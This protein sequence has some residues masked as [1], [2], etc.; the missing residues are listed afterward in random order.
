MNKKYKTELSGMEVK[1]LLTLAKCGPLSGYDFHLGGK[2]QR[3]E[4]KALMASST[5]EEVKKHLGPQ[6]LN[7]IQRVETRGR[8]KAN[9]LGR[10]KKLWWLTEEGILQA[11]TY[12]ANSK[13]LK[14]YTKKIY[15][16]NED[17]SLLFEIIEKFPKK[18]REVY[19]NLIRFEKG[20][21]KLTAM[22]ITNSEI[23]DFLKVLMKYPTYRSILKKMKKMI[24]KKL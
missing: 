24:L 8:P 19:S 12:G 11:L 21:L 16:L 14:T 23:E 6:G 1:T 22:P 13:K 7:L 9:R 18:F 3:G 4:R 15:G 17:Y 5:W 2:P 10:R 20:G